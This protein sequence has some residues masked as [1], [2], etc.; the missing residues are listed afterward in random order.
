MLRN[1]LVDRRSNISACRRPTGRAVVFPRNNKKDEQWDSLPKTSNTTDLFVL[2]L[3]DIHHAGKQF[4][5][6]LP[7]MAEKATGQKLAKMAESKVNLRA[8]S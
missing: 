5:K 4:V 7:K 1:N 6:A 3:Q 8:A 2:R